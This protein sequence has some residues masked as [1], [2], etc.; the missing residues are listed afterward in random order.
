MS[1]EIPRG[2]P[3][4]QGQK[5]HLKVRKSCLK[6]KSIGNGHGTAHRNQRTTPFPKFMYL[7]YFRKEEWKRKM[8][9]HCNQEQFC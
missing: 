4:K 2:N 1:K 8:C 6:K 3:S 7:V 5:P 9:G